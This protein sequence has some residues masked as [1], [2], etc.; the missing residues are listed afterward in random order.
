M[1]EHGSR[2]MNRRFPEEGLVKSGSTKS[3]FRA[4]FSRYIG[5][6]ETFELS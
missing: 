1:Q 5:A 2:F 4:L 3:I 6:N